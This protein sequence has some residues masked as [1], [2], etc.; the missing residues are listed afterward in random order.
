LASDLKGE[1]RAEAEARAEAQALF[2]LPF[3]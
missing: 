1:L 2:L 3:F